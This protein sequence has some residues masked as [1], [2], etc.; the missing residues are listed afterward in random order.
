MM[1]S[2][3]GRQL[4]CSNEVLSTKRKP[5][6]VTVKVVGRLCYKKQPRFKAAG[7]QQL[8]RCLIASVQTCQIVN[9]ATLLCC[10]KERGK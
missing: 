1:K 4:Q 9:N 3:R 10:L 2:K 7:A 6:V 5:A 8:T